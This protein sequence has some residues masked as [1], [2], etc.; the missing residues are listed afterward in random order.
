MLTRLLVSAQFSD[1]AVSV[2]LADELMDGESASQTHISFSR[3]S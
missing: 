1:I 2:F 3:R